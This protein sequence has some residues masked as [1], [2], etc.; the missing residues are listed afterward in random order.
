MIQLTISPG[1]YDVICLADELITDCI[2]SV[3]VIDTFVDVQCGIA[4]VLW[5]GRGSLDGISSLG[6]SHP[7]NKQVK[8]WTISIPTQASAKATLAGS[9][10]DFNFTDPTFILQKHVFL[11][12]NKTA[13]PH[14]CCAAVNFR[15]SSEL[16]F[17]PCWQ[18]WGPGLCG[19]LGCMLW[20]P[21]HAA[22]RGGVCMPVQWGGGTLGGPDLLTWQLLVW[23]AAA[24]EFPVMH[25]G[26]FNQSA[27][28]A[29]K[30]NESGVRR[31]AYIVIYS[32][33]PMCFSFPSPTSNGWLE[34]R[35]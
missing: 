13:A 8:L 22:Q 18:G 19:L 25:T 35:L 4:S 16:D 23:L 12:S 6:L 29:W 20:I 11:K 21:G 9:A 32:R 24:S 34:Q 30:G 27:G 28:N 5:L 3:L 2:C 17:D 33:K 10:C 26:V 1:F 7:P 15:S 31:N 14:S